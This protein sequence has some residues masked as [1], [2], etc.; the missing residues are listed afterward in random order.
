MIQIISWQ[1]G[2]GVKRLSFKIYDFF[3]HF[4]LKWV[5]SSGLPRTKYPEMEMAG[6]KY[7]KMELAGTKYPKIEYAGTEYPK[8]TL[9]GNK[10]SKME[11][12]GTKYPKMELAGTTYLVPANSTGWF[13]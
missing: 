1:K 7:P 13:F 6:T 3:Q 10:Y 9:A 2:Q 5:S 11:L 8:V 12:A 4:G